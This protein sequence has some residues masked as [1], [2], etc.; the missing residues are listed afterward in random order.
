[1]LLSMAARSGASEEEL[2]EAADVLPRLDGPVLAEVL[3]ERQ[4]QR[5]A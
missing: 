1:M 2:V 4:H 5:L 3:R